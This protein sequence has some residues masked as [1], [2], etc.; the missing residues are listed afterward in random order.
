MKLL[1]DDP[2]APAPVSAASQ[3][4]AGA[5]GKAIPALRLDQLADGAEAIVLAID[6][7]AAPT[8][9]VWPQQLQDLGF[10][11]G[12]RVAV[13]RRG[14]PGADPLVVRVGVSTYALR[15]AEAACIAVAA[16]CAAP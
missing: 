14:W 9:S 16:P 2:I 6:S 11:P 7:H 4:R 1:P 8:D 10:V 5:A 13:M 3:V 15:R 12:E